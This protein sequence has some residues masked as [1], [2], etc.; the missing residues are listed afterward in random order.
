MSINTASYSEISQDLSAAISWIKMYGVSVHKTRYEKYQQLLDYWSK[1]YANVSESEGNKVFPDFVTAIVEAVSLIRVHKAFQALSKEQTD[2]LR[3][4]IAK[5]VNGPFDTAME[6]SNTNS[7]RNHLFE[8]V[9]L[10]QFHAPSSDL[11]ADLS[12]A[13]DAGFKFFNHQFH[14]ECKRPQSNK[15]LPKLMK[16]AINQLGEKL[17]DV[18]IYKKALIAID[19]SKIIN[20]KGI[21]YK[22]NNPQELAEF[23]SRKVKAFIDKNASKWIET[24]RNKNNRILAVAVRFAFPAILTDKKMIIASS[25]WGFWPTPCADQ[26]EI[27]LLLKIIDIARQ[28]N[29]QTNQDDAHLTDRSQ[30]VRHLGCLA[31]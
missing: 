2:P 5:A 18:K 24:L 9:T 30:H 27:E 17:V 21:T 6:D 31:R 10:A 22:A 25:Q 26:M 11:I 3:R 19:A 1:A 4:R 23:M 20:P 14:I 16:R 12:P 29:P 15:G 8:L 7:G 13:F 28:V